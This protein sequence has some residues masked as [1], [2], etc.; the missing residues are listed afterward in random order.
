MFNCLAV[1]CG[2]ILSPIT[3]DK[4]IQSYLARVPSGQIRTI[5][6]NTSIQMMPGRLLRNEVPLW[7]KSPAPLSSRPKSTWKNSA[8]ATA[9]SSQKPARSAR[10]A[11]TVTQTP[12]PSAYITEPTPA[13]AADAIS[14]V[15][16]AN[17]VS[18]SAKDMMARSA[19][20]SPSHLQRRSMTS[21]TP[22]S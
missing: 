9:K 17:S 8:F 10:A 13:C 22:I 4:R 18:S 16:S 20:L 19:S 2:V 6:L 12:L 14:R 21:P 15:V 3:S 1:L 7:N 5:F 11:I